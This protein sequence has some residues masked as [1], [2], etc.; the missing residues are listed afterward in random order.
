MLGVPDAYELPLDARLGLPEGRHQ[1]ADP[2]Q[3]R[4]RLRAVPAAPG[5]GASRPVAQ[6][7]PCRGPAG[8]CALAPRRPSA[9][10]EPAAPSRAGGGRRT[11]AG[12]TLLDVVVERL[13][14]RGPPAHQVWLPPLAGRRPSTRSCPPSP[15]TADRGLT[16]AARARG[17]GGSRAGRPSWTSRSTS[18]ATCC[19]RTCRGAAGT[20]RSS[21][22]P[23][24]GKS[25]LLRTLH[26][27]ARPHP[28]PARGAVLLPGLRRRRAGRRW[29]GCRTSAACAAGWTR[30]GAAASWPR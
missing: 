11:T 19:G 25:T 4:V 6:P 10:A 18:A 17:S 1:H 13:A 22:G 27:R 5:H 7:V 29:P 30:S 16:T 15:T 3:G 24:S 20:W 14:G 28:H 12:E 2:V 21:G 8:P 9:A 23:Q 26:R